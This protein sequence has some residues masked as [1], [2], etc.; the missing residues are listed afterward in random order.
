MRRNRP[1]LAVAAA[2]LL[3]S[4]AC[5][6]GEKPMP[7]EVG[8]TPPPSMDPVAESYVKLVLAVGHHD[9]SYVDAYYGPEALKKAVEEE[10]PP[11]DQ[12]RAR[13]VE[14]RRALPR[15][16]ALGGDEMLSLRRDYLD[17]Q[18]GA[19]VS[20][21]DRLG[22]RKMTFDQESKAL[23]DAVAPRE[24][25][26]HFQRI[27]DDLEVLLP[28]GGPL[29]ARY[30]A[31]KKAFIISPAKLDTV[32]RAAIEACREKTLEH[33][34]L[35]PDESFEIEY[36]TGKPW[37]GYNWYQ[38]GFKSII[39]VNTDLPIYIDRAID[40]AC[41]EG[42]PGHHVYNALL[43]WRLTRD[44]GWVEFSVYPLYSPQSLIAEGTANFGIEMAF[45]GEE[46]VAFEKKRLF[47]LAGLDPAR[48]GLYYEVA[49][50]VEQLAYAGN[51]AARLYLDGEI[52]A[53]AATQRLMTFALTPRA[54][55]E[56][57]VRFIETYRA[58]VIN[59]NLGK[60]LVRAWVEAESGGDPSRRWEVFGALL[61]SPRLPSGLK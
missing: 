58:Y 18:L 21:V 55:A 10:K 39:Q 20:H 46:R 38:G 13:A 37:S 42:Y 61:S 41:H 49:E 48:A 59:Y 14:L 43:E 44:R 24:R 40:L 30:E 1:G 45:P 17:T 35:P 51:E 52:D 19:L 7:P 5:S 57:R 8:S 31:F 11:L 53:E 32:F 23:Y 26:E 12:I 2:A 60:D 9:S 3:M 15:A 50:K 6:Q 34:E 56:Q 36:V 27:L 47:P 25:D 22:G 28:G 29:V 54:R 33:L 4:A 16:S